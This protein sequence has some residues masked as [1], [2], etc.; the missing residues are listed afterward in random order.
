MSETPVTPATKTLDSAGATYRISHHGKVKSAEEAAAAR[1]IPVSALAKSLVVRVNAGEYVI[2]LV[3]ADRSLDYPKLRSL[4]GVRRL[5]MPSP[6]EAKEATGYAR[7]TITPLGAGDWPT[8][9]DTRL[10]SQD[11]ISVGSGQHGWAIAIDPNHLID[12]TNA[13]VADITSD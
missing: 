5:T 7:G 13:L 9:I 4:L 10:A 6:E 12:V 8:Y 3:S 2:V 1:G 11:E